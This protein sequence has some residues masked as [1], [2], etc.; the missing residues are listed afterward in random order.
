MAI[1]SYTAKKGKP[2]YRLIL[3]LFKF[4]NF[5]SLRTLTSISPLDFFFPYKNTYCSITFLQNDV[6]SLFY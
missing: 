3:P 5:S 6:N 1:K 4:I 2:N